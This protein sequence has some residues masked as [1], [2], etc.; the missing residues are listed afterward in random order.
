MADG[1]ARIVTTSSSRAYVAG[2][3]DFETVKDGPA[4]VEK[5]TK[6]LYDQ[7]KLVTWCLDH[8][9]YTKFD[10]VVAAEL[11]RRYGDQGIVS[12]ALNPG[13]SVQLC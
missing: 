12:V 13:T 6:A 8:P 3:I 2:K 1:K 9:R 7:S 11:A 4:R 5:G 10:A